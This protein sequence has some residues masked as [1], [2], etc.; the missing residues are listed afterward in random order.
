MALLHLMMQM[1]SSFRLGFDV[2]VVHFNHQ[3][4][5]LREA[6]QEYDLVRFWSER[7]YRIPFH[8]R[9]LSE[10]GK[11]APTSSSFQ[12]LARHWRRAECLNIIQEQHQVDH[13]L[14][15]RCDESSH[16]S[17]STA[18][19]QGRDKTTKPREYCIVT[20]H[21]Q[22]DQLEGVLLKMLRGTHISRL[23]PVSINSIN[24]AVQCSACSPAHISTWI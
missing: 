10:E 1:R 7:F 22:D 16:F 19:G 15:L 23:T 18:Q 24:S 20:G 13:L 8:Y 17:S 12:E 3:K 5:T 2:S 11:S 6:Q 9:E 4:R 14:R 21:H